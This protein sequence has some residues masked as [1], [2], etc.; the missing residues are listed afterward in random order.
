MLDSDSIC[1][2]P[3]LAAG[4]P[5]RSLRWRRVTLLHSRLQ[6]ITITIDILMAFFVASAELIA[7][8][9]T[10]G[11]PVENRNEL[12]IGSTYLLRYK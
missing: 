10:S 7:G 8:D 12:H 11:I 2:I 3:D 9:G 5:Q 1:G 4:D 6:H